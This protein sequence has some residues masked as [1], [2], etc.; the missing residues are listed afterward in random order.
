[1][2][3]TVNNACYRIRYASSA[4]SEVVRISDS[5]SY[6]AIADGRYVN[7]SGDTMTGLYNRLAYTE[8]I[9]PAFHGY[10]ESAVP[11]CLAFFDVNYFYKHKNL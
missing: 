9:G 3:M 1:M 4:I 7:V 2:G 8:M 11:C 10:Q 5:N 6:S